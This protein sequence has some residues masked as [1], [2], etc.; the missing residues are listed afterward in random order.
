MPLTKEEFE[1]IVAKGKVKT[2]KDFNE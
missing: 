1:I 2:T